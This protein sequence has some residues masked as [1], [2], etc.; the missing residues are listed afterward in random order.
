MVAMDPSRWTKSWTGGFPGSSTLLVLSQ[1][2]VAAYIKSD[3]RDRLEIKPYCRKV[4]C[5][6]QHHRGLIIECHFTQSGP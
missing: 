6:I 2:R 3:R 5:G 4:P 1:A